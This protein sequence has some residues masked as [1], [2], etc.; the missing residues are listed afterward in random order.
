ML[1]A[2][3]MACPAAY[4]AERDEADEPDREPTIVEKL[5]RKID[6]V[7][8]TEVSAQRA[9][10]WWSQVADIPVA[11]N[12]DALAESAID[13]ETPITIQLHRV[14][15][16]YVLMRILKQLE[17]VGEEPLLAEVSPA[18]VQILT[19]TQALKKTVVRVYDVRDLLH[20]IPNFSDVPQST[21][22]GSGT[23]RY[24]S[25][26]SGGGAAGGTG[27][28]FLNLESSA[29]PTMTE[30]CEALAQVIRDS[31]EPDIWVAN[32][33]EHCSIACYRGLLIIKAP[34]FIHRR[35]NLPVKR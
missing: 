22:G 29:G 15:T 20:E 10:N 13:P 3:L 8:L 14:S 11:V 35:I 30:R 21:L 23:S 7:E 18:D 24:G 28:S 2:G 1:L 4:A 6:R 26:Q 17:A 32:G 25:G 27:G 19:R 33:G 31:V 34:A 5:V 9:V 16:A 12:W